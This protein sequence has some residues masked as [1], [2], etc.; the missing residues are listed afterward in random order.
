M[1]ANNRVQNGIVKTSTA[2]RPAPPSTSES[3]ESVT[4][5]VVWTIPSNRVSR[6]RVGQN[7]LRISGSI[8]SRARAPMNVRWAA[9]FTGPASSSASFS[10][11][12]L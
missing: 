7:G 1:A 3:C 4:K 12:Q 6:T 10:N 11:T 5:I 8:A 2:L 9:K